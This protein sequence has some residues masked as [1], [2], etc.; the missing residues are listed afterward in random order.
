MLD[1]GGESSVFV[2]KDDKAER[3][4]VVTGFSD[5]GMIEIIS[6]IDDDDSVVTLGQAGLKH[7]AL[8]TVIGSD[9][10]ER[11]VNAPAD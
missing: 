3:R 6:G 7:E 10:E 8:V 9:E 5:K 2:V 11:P 4:V 1:D